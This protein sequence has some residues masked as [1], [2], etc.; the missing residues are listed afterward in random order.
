MGLTMI[1][2]L[3]SFL[4]FTFQILFWYVIFT[5]LINV[6][7]VWLDRRL[8][9][10]SKEERQEIIKRVSEMIHNVRQEQHGDVH[11]WFD[12]D[13]AEFL[14]QGRNDDEVREHLLKRFKGHIFLID[15]D[16]A[17]AGPTLE[18]ISIEKLKLSTDLTTIQ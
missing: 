13:S 1:E 5:V 16:R 17:L 14:G 7:N 3:I 15:E 12:K 11:Y 10:Y 4:D 9:S 8:S 6:I 2:F 18:P